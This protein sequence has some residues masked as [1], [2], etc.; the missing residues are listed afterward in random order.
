MRWFC[1][2]VFIVPPLPLKLYDTFEI[3]RQCGANEFCTGKLSRANNAEGMGSSVR[4]YDNI[5]VPLGVIMCDL[6]EPIT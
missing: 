5:N 4:G 6:S 1:G 3:S 2:F